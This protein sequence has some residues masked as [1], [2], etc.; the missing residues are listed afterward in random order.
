MLKAVIFDLDGVVA[1]SHPIHEMAWKALLAEAGL[2]PETINVDFLY[3]GHPRREILKHY[4]GVLSDS[5]IRHWGRRK[6][7]LYELSAK[8]LQAKPGI[9]RVLAQLHEAGIACAIATSAGRKRTIESLE[10]LGLHKYFPIVVTGEEVRNAKPA[11]DIFLL[12]AKK[13]AVEPQSSVVVEDS[14][15]GV[16]AAVAGEMKCVGFTSPERF[17]EL[18]AA[19]ADDVI[20]DFPQDV[21][22][23]FQSLV[24]PADPSDLH[25]A[26]TR[27]K[28]SRQG[29]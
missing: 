1:D 4:L 23:Y 9:P 29:F 20:S 7:E 27:A 25:L 5:E 14:V 11:P 21:V 8:M 16:E 13:L 17:E 18:S 24:S 12:T 6:D 3:A 22:L 2:K 10:H 19:G 15:A 26:S 28:T